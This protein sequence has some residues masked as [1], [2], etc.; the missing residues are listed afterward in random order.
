MK[1]PKNI[2]VLFVAGFGPIVRDRAS[3]RKFYSETLG[4]E[5]QEDTS[6]YLYT[7]ELGGVKHFAL[8]PLTQAAESCFGTDQWPG[9][10]AVPQ[11][12]IEFDVDNIE[13]ATAE[14][15]S[16]GLRTAGCNAKRTLGPGRYAN[17]GAGRS[18]SGHNPYALDAEVNSRVLLVF[19]RPRTTPQGV[20]QEGEIL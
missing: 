6:G 11:A 16:Q 20:S 19:A 14:L 5:F 8:W 1:T 10:L 2:E 17:V 4:L 12:W 7:A 3:S 18:V 13:K 9:N 15:K